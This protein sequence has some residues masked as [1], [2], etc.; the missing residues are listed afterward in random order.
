MEKDALI[1]FADLTGRERLEF[2]VSQLADG[3]LPASRRASVLAEVAWDASLQAMLRDFQ[4]ID[5]GL[6]RRPDW[7]AVD[8]AGLEQDVMN[9]VR[10]DLAAEGASIPL[11]LPMTASAGAGTA[12]GAW[13]TNPWSSA[14]AAAAALVIGLGIGAIMMQ[15]SGPGTLQVAVPS[16][17]R[18]GAMA[19]GTL[20]VVGPG[21][22]WSQSLA[23]ANEPA[24]ADSAVLSVSGPGGAADPSE[25]S[26]FADLV[27]RNF[28]TNVVDSP[29]RVVVA[30]VDGSSET[31]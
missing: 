3:T 31:E 6:T 9:V 19:D 26:T 13:W 30:S 24:L 8:L 21:T 14:V 17:P 7:A 16:E 22:A 18:T 28:G 12:G 23:A 29:S 20:E 5:A 4:Q 27:A 10:R 1:N 25:Q 2:E 11:R 15:E